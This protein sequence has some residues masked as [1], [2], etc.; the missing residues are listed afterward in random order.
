MTPLSGVIWR[1][2]L[3][4]GDALLCVCETAVTSWDTESGASR[5]VAEASCAIVATALDASGHL[6]LLD[7]ESRGT[8]KLA[9]AAAFWR[10]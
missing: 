7:K 2:F 9:L 4:S 8:L 5:T 3:W 10:R 1:R 6:L